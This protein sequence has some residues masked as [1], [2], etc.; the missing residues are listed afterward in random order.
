LII[1]KIVFNNQH[2]TDYNHRLPLTK[3][4]FVT[5]KGDVTLSNVT[6]FPGFAQYGEPWRFVMVR[7]IYFLY[8]IYSIAKSFYLFLGNS[9]SYQYVSW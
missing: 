6:I 1:F 5:V 9:S 4:E 7:I 2:A 3:A 8:I